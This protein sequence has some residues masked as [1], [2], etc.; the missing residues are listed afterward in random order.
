MAINANPVNWFEI[1]VTDMERAK[2]FYE[3]VFETQLSIQDMGPLLMAWFP[4]EQGATGS[5][6]TLVKHDQYTPS[7]A[8]TLVYFTVDS[9]EDTLARIQANG[10]K[11]LNPKMA[12]GQYGYVAHFE[13]SEGNRVALH[14]MS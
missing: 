1:P 4:M 14:A 5:T 6:G 8:G 9:I 13:D 11:V 2:S 10:G 3:V 12:I 7:Y